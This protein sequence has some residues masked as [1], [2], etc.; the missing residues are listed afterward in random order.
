MIKHY[1]EFFYP[2]IFIA[3]SDIKNV[4]S[5]NPSKIKIPNGCYGFH[6]FDRSEITIENEYHEPE[7]LIGKSRNHSG[8]FYLGKVMTLNEVKRE[9]P[10]AS[11]LISNMEINNLDKVIKTRC[12][13]FQPFHKM[14]TV[15]E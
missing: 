10:D 5:R 13:N 3:E 8:M 6:F 9:I 4:E 14:D 15:I 12:G 2:G 11:V 7:T 1:V